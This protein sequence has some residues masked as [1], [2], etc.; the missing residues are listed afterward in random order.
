MHGTS[1][2]SRWPATPV[3]VAVLAVG[4]ALVVPAGAAVQ[5]APPPDAQIQGES[6]VVLDVDRRTGRDRP[7]AAQREAAAALGAEVRWNRF[8]TPQSV[9]APGG[10][11]ASGLS[12]DPVEAARTFLRQQRSLF[13]L[14][15]AEVADLAVLGVNAIGAGNAVLLRQRFGGVPAGHDG[16]VALG[17][18][19]GRV[20]YI[21]SS[22]SEA[23]SLA[24]GPAVPPERGFAVAAGSA[25][26]PV[27]RD[28]VET[29]G[30]REGWTR[31]AVEGF[32]DPQRI[33][34][35]AV[36]LPT[37]AAR[38]AYET[39]VADPEDSLGFSVFVDAATGEVLIRESLIDY[40]TDNPKW[41]VFPA[42]PPLDYSTDDTRVIWC[43]TTATP[44]C[45]RL[46]DDPA[47]PF[48]WDADAV[49]GASTFQTRGNSARATEKWSPQ[50][51][52]LGGGSTQGTNYSN[53]AT[54]DYVYDWSNEWF[55]QQCNPSV[56][57]TPDG[58]DI[59][60][61]R[62]N[63]H[64]MHN[65]M[66]DW[67]YLLGFTERTWNGQAH[68]FGRGEDELDP[69][70]GNAQAGGVTGGF[71]NFA[72][73]D[74]ANQFTPPD[75][76]VPVTNMF[77]WQ[78]IPGAFYAPCVDGDYDM[79]VIGHEYTH[80][81]SNRMVNGP[82]GRLLGLQA[83]AMGESWSDYVAM[84][85]LFEYGF[86]PADQDNPFA[87]GAYVTGDD[88]A[89]IRNYGMNQS[90]LNYSDVGYDF[91][92]TTD[93]A[94]ECV[95]L[96][97]VHA[98]G[99]IWS[100]TLFDLRQ[101]FNAR[102]G[103][104]TSATQA[105]CADGLIPVA[106]CPG[107]RRLI[108][109]VFDAW[110]LMPGPTT[111]LGARDAMLAADMVRFGGANQDLL[112]NGFAR[113]G[114]GQNAT[115]TASDDADPISDFTSPHAN[116]ASVTFKTVGDGAGAPAELYVGHYEARVTPVADSDPASPLDETF[117]IVPGTYDFLARAD[118]YG[119][120]RFRFT[121]KPGQVRD[122]PVFLRR[123]LA[124]GA[125]GA[126][127]T[128]DGGNL[129][130]LIDDTEVTNWAFIGNTDD[131]VQEEAE[132][133]RVTVA[134]D[135]SQVWQVRRVQ[136]S[137]MLRPRLP[138]PFPPPPPP[139]PRPPNP[140]PTQNRFSALRSFQI[141]VCRAGGAVDCTQ[142]AHFIPVLT[143]E[144]AFPSVVPRPRAPELT[145]RSFDI[146]RVQATHVRLVVLD[147][148]CTGQEQFL[149]EQDQD[150]RYQ[151]DC[152]QGSAQDDI[153][154]AAELQVFRK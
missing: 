2:A 50:P 1:H 97:Q 88:V 42:Y 59:D 94:G 117:Q 79:S 26:R 108:Q 27:S 110:L 65:R 116:E 71:P 143:A 14:S 150:P 51:P 81:I 100:A 146:P 3:I 120:T 74:N 11:L 8:G 99:E 85:Y 46:V 19:D 145:I 113:R 140:D 95:I 126:T 43:G 30:R 121:L 98:D 135:P 132:G 127:V 17:I 141:L 134:L 57:S 47:S 29:L 111:M 104:G 83:N 115:S 93:Q 92:C 24:A 77:L 72:G 96:G 89:G 80:M 25:G 23:T 41:K 91:V 36:P 125:N 105:Q 6:E 75:G 21:S 82:D 56:F 44:D 147:N 38:P 67:S 4:A 15:D 73:R 154:R 5:P 40:E 18:R 128:G 102:Y 63:L 54:R 119:T 66:H 16:L 138:N 68:N 136:V 52:D 133:R 148:Q 152:I 109:L 37:G 107:N 131:A 55:E 22:L 64:A 53:S 32:D 153:V 61:A 144:D 7:T 129:D 106:S 139:E 62:A 90:P 31:L 58:N 13:G 49:T 142:D 124:S 149:G 12:K 87:V 130:K 123:N 76:Q 35:V 28:D 10:F 112:W 60:A 69:E 48:A 33:R 84:E 70:H 78:S 122:L 118:G 9:F 114:L 45:E 151:T 103:A 86:L 34:E 20:A 39:V 101:T 137:A